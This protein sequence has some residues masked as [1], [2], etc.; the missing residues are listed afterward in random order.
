MNIDDPEAARGFI[1]TSYAQSALKGV[2]MNERLA[3]YAKLR[4]MSRGLEI[5]GIYREEP[6][7]MLLLAQAR[8]TG[9]W[10][11][12]LFQYE[13]EAPRGILSVAIDPLDPDEA[14]RKLAS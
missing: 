7:E 12:L 10:Y 14:Q 1:L 13:S 2:A 9:E 5:R 3:V 11:G 6:D 8:G 4:E